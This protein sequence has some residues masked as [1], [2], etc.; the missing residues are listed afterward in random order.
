MGEIIT[1]FGWPSVR[2]ASHTQQEMVLLFALLKEQI[3][4]KWKLWC[5]RNPSNNLKSC[6]GWRFDS[7]I[8]SLMLKS[9]K[10]QM[11]HRPLSNIESLNLFG[12]R[13]TRMVYNVLRFLDLIA[14]EM[15]I[16]QNT[17]NPR[18]LHGTFVWIQISVYSYFTFFLVLDLSTRILFHLLLCL[19]ALNAE[20][21][22]PKVECESAG[23]DWKI[24]S[25]INTTVSPH[26]QRSKIFA[27]KWINILIEAQ[28]PSN[29]NSW[30]ENYYV[31]QRSFA[32]R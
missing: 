21:Y 30:R 15:N 25:G 29:K 1:S 10:I 13:T 5:V 19:W 16:L 12:V 28:H 23:N 11:L 31:A 24:I 9:K 18:T 2:R 6:M 27:H 3:L 4:M 32:R 8:T 22:F 26:M 14:N 20:R 17:I 7:T